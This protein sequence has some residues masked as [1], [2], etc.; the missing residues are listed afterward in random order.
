MQ[1]RPVGQGC[2][3]SGRLKLNSSASEYHFV[4]DCGSNSDHKFIDREIDR[5]NS[6]IGT[7]PIDMV[8]VSHFDHD[9][10]NKVKKLISGRRVKRLILPYITL[11]ERLFICAKS[12]SNDEDYINFIRDPLQYFITGGGN[13]FNIDEIDVIG[14]DGEQQP[15]NNLDTPPEPINPK[16]DPFTDDMLRI[17]F[18]DS[19]RTDSVEI[20]KGDEFFQNI[21]KKTGRTTLSY[22]PRPLDLMVDFLWEFRFYLRKR[23]D[24]TLIA[25]FNSSVKRIKQKHGI[26]MNE[27]LFGDVVR[28]EL[29]TE[30]KN[31]F[32]DVNSTSLVVFHSPTFDLTGTRV[33]IHRTRPFHFRHARAMHPFGTLLTGDI[34]LR[35]H[36][37][38]ADF[39]GYFVNYLPKV[40]FFQIPHHGSHLNWNFQAHPNPLY[41]FNY[42]IVNYGIGR[43]HHPSIRVLDEILTQSGGRI[44]HNNEIDPFNY[45]LFY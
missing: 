26:V 33:I 22:Y 20:P 6:K 43:K 13:D 35:N 4:Y 44:F 5:F 21:P 25:D 27:D 30:Y 12:E 42:Y 31:N 40:S 18:S 7:L 39:T 2:F 17:K 1:F 16:G 15:E 24:L 11:E 14:D 45:S 38:F 19:I 32:G 9:H 36:N 23:S 29:R 34:N 28:K 8:I 37:D 3:Y 41:D 10:V